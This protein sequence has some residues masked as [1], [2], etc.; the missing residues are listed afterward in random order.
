MVE[1]KEMADKNKDDQELQEVFDQRV[2]IHDGKKY[3]IDDPDI[4][5]VR[6]ADWQYSK[7]YNEALLA[8]VTTAAQMQDILE[9]RQIIGKV[10]EAEREKLILDL[11][12]KSAQLEAMDPKQD[13]EAYRNIM[14]EVEDLRNKLFRINQKASSPMSNTCEQ[15]AEDTRMEFMTSSMVKDEDGNRVWES[16]EDYKLF[17]DAALAMR[18]RYECMLALQ[19]LDSD[20]LEKTPE[21]VARKAL[22][23]LES[24]DSDKD[25]L[26]EADKAEDK[27]PSKKPPTAKKKPTKK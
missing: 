7:T 1:D 5:S 12:T 8:G 14:E 15:I 10:Y 6:K 24:G 4:E 9:E 16:Y 19:G 23:A 21:A 27:S 11:E 17:P 25:A 2:F 3:F 13:V 26:P 20:F 18:A 22:E